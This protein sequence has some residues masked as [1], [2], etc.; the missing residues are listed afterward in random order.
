MTL[1]GGKPVRFD[2]PEAHTVTVVVLSGTVEINGAQIVHRS[3]VAIPG[4]AGDALTIE[5]AGDNKLLILVGAAVHEPVVAHGP[6][7][8]NTMGE[9]KKAM[10]DYQKGRFGQI[11]CRIPRYGPK[12]A[13][14]GSTSSRAAPLSRSR[15]SSVV[16]QLLAQ[17]DYQADAHEQQHQCER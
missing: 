15:G 1:A 8:M 11:G 16:A 2:V 7:V 17:S 14:F 10:M 5:A 9:I 12:S 3:G 4:Q 6:F 13:I